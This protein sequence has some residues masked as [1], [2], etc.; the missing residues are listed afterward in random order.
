VAEDRNQFHQTSAGGFIRETNQ[1]TLITDAVSG[2]QIV[3]HAWTYVD[4]FGNGKLDRG[5]TAVAV[6][7]FLMGSADQQVKQKLRDVLLNAQG[8]SS[9]D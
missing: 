5:M 6:E 2:A 7:D 4:P 3:E 1:W 8:A 9:T